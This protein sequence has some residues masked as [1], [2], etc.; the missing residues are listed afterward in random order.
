MAAIA[1]K[2]WTKAEVNLFDLRRAAEVPT[3]LIAEELGRSF[4]SVHARV[5]RPNTKKHRERMRALEAPERIVE[6]PIEPPPPAYVLRERDIRLSI[7]ATSLTQVQFRDP[8]EG[9]S[10]L[11]SRARN[12][13]VQDALEICAL[14]TGKRG[15]FVALADIY[16]ISRSS[17]ESIINGS[18][19][20]KLIP[21]KLVPREVVDND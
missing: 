6:E 5:Q 3:R 2:R 4:C 19:F 13:S 8:V 9:Y 7:P 11:A 16:G 21:A 17:V 10:A 12:I 1:Q 15:E 20:E 18:F 14:Y